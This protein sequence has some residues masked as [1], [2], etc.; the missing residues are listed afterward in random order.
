[1]LKFPWRQ[2]HRLGNG[3]SAQAP[4]QADVV[5]R[6]DHERR[7]QRHENQCQDQCGGPQQVARR[8]R[9]RDAGQD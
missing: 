9:R 3:K 4:D 7:K 8:N 5:N 1:M 2:F 6:H